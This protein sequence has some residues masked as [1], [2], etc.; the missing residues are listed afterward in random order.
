[1]WQLR[2]PSQWLKRA[3]VH[4]VSTAITRTLSFIQIVKRLWQHIRENNLQNPDKKTE[5]LNDEVFEE[6]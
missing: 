5:I 2:A 3:I 6:M 4:V 1:M